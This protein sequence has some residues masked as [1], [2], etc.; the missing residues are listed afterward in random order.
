VTL[1]APTD[2]IP[3]LQHLEDIPHAGISPFKKERKPA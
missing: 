2:W 1:A 3:L